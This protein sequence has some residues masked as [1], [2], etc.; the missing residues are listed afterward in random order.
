[1]LIMWQ[2]VI[3]VA[4]ETILEIYGRIQNTPKVFL[5][6]DALNEEEKES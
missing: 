6:D 2:K 5:S 1:M 4:R 3:G